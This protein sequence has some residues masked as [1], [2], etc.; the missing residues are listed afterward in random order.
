MDLG[1]TYLGLR[2]A[3]PL[4]A[5]A[6]PLTGD[7]T[8]LRALEEAGAAAVVLPSLF[9]E[10]IGADPEQ[11][12]LPDD[13]AE[14]LG[15]A[16]T[17]LGIPV[18]A[19]LNG[20]T[21][22]GWLRLAAQL[23]Q[24]GAD[25]IELNVYAVETDQY[26]SGAAVEERTLRIVHQVKTAVTI[27]VAVKLSPFYTALAHVADRLAD[28]RADGLVL[29]NRFVQ[30]DID[31]ETLTVTSGLKLSHSDETRLA[32]RWIAILRGRAPLS[33]AGG[34]GVHTGEDVVKLLL[35][36]ADVVTL[37]SAALEAGPRAFETLTTDLGAWL[38]RQGYDSVDRMRGL[39]S[40][41]AIAD[42]AAFERAQYVQALEQ[43][44]HAAPVAHQGR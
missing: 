15:A 44:L 27:P 10:R 31:V 38:E 33:L 32:L 25:A 7:L 1:T 42:P 5:S 23:Q 20:T 4:I 35:A 26:T 30:P 13:Y 17:T 34:G 3:G 36:G 8:S 24:A 9:E 40:Q 28:A 19:S 37:A 18:I 12:Q 41:Q 43:G 16:K 29:F 21:P 22:G 39:L 6:S 14:L 11:L 2:L